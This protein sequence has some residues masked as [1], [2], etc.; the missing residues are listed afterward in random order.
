MKYTTLIQYNI[1]K[2]SWN[3]STFSRKCSQIFETCWVLLVHL[4]TT[5]NSKKTVNSIQER[6]SQIQYNVER[7]SHET[8]Q[9]FKEN[10]VKYFFETYWVLLLVHL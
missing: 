2:R 9:L 4:W 10:A 7:K 8:Y 5:V 6:F 1:E 3:V